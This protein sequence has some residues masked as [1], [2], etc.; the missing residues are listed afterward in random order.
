MVKILIEIILF[1]GGLFFCYMWWYTGNYLFGI[2]GIAFYFFGLY[3]LQLNLK[4]KGDRIQK[5]KNKYK[6]LHSQTKKQ[7]P[8]KKR[9]NIKRIRKSKKK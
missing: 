2:V 9:Y 7:S 5:L 1:I 6:V 4:R 8:R 3:F